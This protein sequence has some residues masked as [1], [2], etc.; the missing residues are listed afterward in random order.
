MYGEKAEDPKAREQF[1]L[2]FGRHRDGCLTLAEAARV[3][4]MRPEAFTETLRKR[5]AVA[6][7]P[8]LARVGEDFSSFREPS[9]Y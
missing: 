2:A 6:A 9:T 5:D 4:E 1:E 7:D 3:A 8:R